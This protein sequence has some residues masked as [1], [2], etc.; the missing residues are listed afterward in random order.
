MSKK[1]P[2]INARDFATILNINP[3]QTP[4]QLLEQKIENKYPFFG[5]KFTDHGNKYESLALKIYEIQS[6][7]TVDKNQKNIKHPDYPWI[8]GR[9]DGIAEIFGLSEKASKKRKK[10]TCVVEI[11]CPLKKDRTESLTLDNI[12]KY[13]WAQCQVYMNMIGSDIAHYVEYYIDPGAD[14]ITGKLYYIDVPIDTKWWENSLPI[15]KLFHEEI[16][17]YKDE[18]SL[19]S[20]PVRIEEKKWE[21]IFLKS[22][23]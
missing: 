10:Q 11:K 13:Y 8:T 1:I 21:Q 6:G 3:Y 19:N 16:K 7:N 9:L 20:H 17:K 12:P 18:G 14:E 15:I 4:F 22:N 5:N 2:N 23:I